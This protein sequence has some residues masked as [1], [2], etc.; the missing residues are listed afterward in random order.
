MLAR[1]A[2]VL[3]VEAHDFATDDEALD[4]VVAVYRHSGEGAPLA[5]IDGRIDSLIVDDVPSHG[6]Q[7]DLGIWLGQ[8]ADTPTDSRRHM[9]RIHGAEG[10]AIVWIGIVRTVIDRRRGDEDMV[11]EPYPCARCP[12]P[13]H[14]R[15]VDGLVAREYPVILIVGRGCEI[16]EF[17]D[18]GRRIALGV[19]TEGNGEVA[20]FDDHMGKSRVGHPRLTEADTVL[21]RIQLGHEEEGVFRAE[22]E[23]RVEIGAGGIAQPLLPSHGDIAISTDRES[24]VGLAFRFELPDPGFERRLRCRGDRRS[25]HRR[26]G[27]RR[28]DL[29][30]CTLL[31]QF[32]LLL[33]GINALLES[34]K[35]IG[36]LGCLFLR[37]RT[38]SES[39]KQDE[40]SAHGVSCIGHWSS[41]A[42]GEDRELMG[43]HR[44]Q[45]HLSA[46]GYNP[47]E[48]NGGGR[49][50]CRL[51]RI[52]V[53]VG[54]HR[55]FRG[56]RPL[57][58][59]V[60]LASGFSPPTHTDQST[61]RDGVVLAMRGYC[62]G[63][64]STRG[65][66]DHGNCERIASDIRAC[67]GSW[68]A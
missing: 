55:R 39:C 46:M 11:V 56:A 49:S 37:H 12:V 33:Q 8:E 27:W 7:A 10:E 1:T 63:H 14:L 48:R 58:R 24:I 22:E 21:R 38:G 19:G 40:R 52:L 35:L 42:Q 6:G 34:S 65:N 53:T 44:S 28:L 68:L 9:G 57:D 29:Y 43:I 54:G 20:R 23:D 5:V 32:D 2:G 18:P 41:L 60:I 50:G 15:A 13:P 59:P 47:T 17:I 61:H 3:I 25:R 30:L 45:A 67:A 51:G 62:P 16:G 31:Q 64:H 26:T 36:R 4:M 66:S